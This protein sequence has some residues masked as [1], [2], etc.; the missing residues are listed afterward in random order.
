MSYM[1]LPQLVRLTGKSD[2]TVR[3]ALIAAGVKLKREKGIRGYRIPE[4]TALNF[5]RKQ[6]PEC[7]AGKEAA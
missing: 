3:R 7:L 6:W 1:T 5:V 2:S 4:N